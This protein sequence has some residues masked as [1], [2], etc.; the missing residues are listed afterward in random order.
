MYSALPIVVPFHDV[1]AERWSRV[2]SGSATE[3]VARAG[4][5]EPSRTPLTF[6]PVAARN[7]LVTIPSSPCCEEAQD[8][9]RPP[10]CRNEFRLSYAVAALQGG[11]LDVDVLADELGA[12][13]ASTVATSAKRQRTCAAVPG[14]RRQCFLPGLGEPLSRDG[15]IAWLRGTHRLRGNDR[16]WGMVPPRPDTSLACQARVSWLAVPRPFPT[17]ARG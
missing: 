3:I 15:E 2:G 8:H 9:K 5:D 14:P 1:M 17:V 16:G 11:C 6:R 7:Y 4:P 13:P 12:R 10:L